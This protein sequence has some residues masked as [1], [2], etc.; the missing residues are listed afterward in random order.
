MPNN[1]ISGEMGTPKFSII[2][3]VFNG[4]KYLSGC[5]ADVLGFHVR[6]WEWIIVNDGST[7]GTERICR[8][9]AANDS[10][11][12]IVSYA[13][14][15]GRGYARNLAL[16][17]A[18]G[19]WIVILDADDHSFPDRLDELDAIKEPDFDWVGAP[20]ILVR[21][22]TLEVYGRRD[23][24]HNE[25]NRGNNKPVHPSLIV[26]ADV[27]RTLGYRELKT[28]GGIGED[29]RFLILLSLKY[30]GYFPDR[31]SVLFCEDGEINFRKA[32]HS[33]AILLLT[34]LSVVFRHPDL[35]RLG[36]A[37]R[38]LVGLFG[39]LGVFSVVSFLP[40]RDSLYRKSISRRVSSPASAS[41]KQVAETF[42]RARGL[43]KITA[44]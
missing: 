1:P 41:D 6:D 28:V 30:R 34:C 40:N 24:T 14:N 15:R 21:R 3:A 31:A 18:R 26:R 10:R 12:R 22:E 35:V 33:N 5:H 23:Y 9:L 7:D 29:V 38:A 8:E 16:A 2:T 25:L 37:A 32:L 39:K 20:V 17:E 4:E 42:I 19:K 43:R 27:A 36:D 13:N 44:V 11:I